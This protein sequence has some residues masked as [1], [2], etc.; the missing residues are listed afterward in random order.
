MINRKL[1]NVYKGFVPQIFRNKIT[2]IRNVG[3]LD[4]IRKKILAYYTSSE[5]IV[6][7]EIKIVLK[8]L[9]KN[10]LTIFPYQFPGKYNS[11]EINVYKD[12]ERNLLYVLHEEKRMYFK[13]SWS[14]KDIQENYTNL[15]IEQDKDSPHRYL[16][17]N[18]KVE[19]NDLVADI[20][21]AEGIFALSVVHEAKKIYLF[22]TDCEW[23]EALEATF[24]PWIDK[25]EI[26]NKF[27]SDKNNEENITLDEFSGNKNILFDFIKIDV[28]GAELPLLKGAHNIF[29]GSHKIK[30]SICTYHK[31][32]DEELFR[33]VFKNY[34]LSVNPSSGYMIFY[35]DPNLSAPY[36]RRGL[37]RANK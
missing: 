15:L 19:E 37:L 8:Y 32:E 2:M 18:F 9:Q 10:P 31:S 4:T 13:R 11:S 1:V 6:N 3:D 7:D 21:A 24:S 26:I 17:Q 25:V 20:G 35:F 27:V 33:N 34:G 30:V 14:K 22:E 28:D 29:S 12:G 36:L 16:T 5:S 23:I